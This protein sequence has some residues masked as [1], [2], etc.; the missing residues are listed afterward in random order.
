[1]PEN[2]GATFIKL[3][4]VKSYSLRIVIYELSQQKQLRSIKARKVHT[5]PQITATTNPPKPLKHIIQ[6]ERNSSE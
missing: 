2:K 4:E 3:Q 1:M 6:L 5:I